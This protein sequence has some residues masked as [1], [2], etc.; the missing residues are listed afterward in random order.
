[1]GLRPPS[2]HLGSVYAWGSRCTLGGAAM[3]QATGSL[4]PYWETRI[5]F[6]APG[7]LRVNQQMGTVSQINLKQQITK[8]ETINR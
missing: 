7:W 3:V 2:E 4:P 6:L 5:E 8:Q 1:M